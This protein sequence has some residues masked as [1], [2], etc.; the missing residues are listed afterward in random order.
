MAMTLDI[1][2]VAFSYGDTMLLGRLYD[3]Y[4]MKMS[5][6]ITCE[7]LAHVSHTVNSCVDSFKEALLNSQRS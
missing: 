3:D 5:S 7:A 1:R 6:S 4:Q 2:N